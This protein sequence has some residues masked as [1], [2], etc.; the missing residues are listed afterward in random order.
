M[1]RFYTHRL[2]NALYVRDKEG[3]SSLDETAACEVLVDKVRDVLV[4]HFQS[5][6]VMNHQRILLCVDDCN[7]RQ[8]MSV[9]L[10]LSMN[11]VQNL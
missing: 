9:Q 6:R 1:E 10:L 4:D 8:I 5:S 3:A 11:I 2:N 7:G